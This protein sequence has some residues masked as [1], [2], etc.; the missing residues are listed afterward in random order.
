MNCPACAH[1]NR[2]GAKFCEECAAALPR[3]CASCGAELRATAKFCDECGAPVAAKPPPASAPLSSTSPQAAAGERSESGSSRKIVT[4]VFADLVGSTALHERLDPESVRRFMESYYGAM[5]GAVEAHGGRVT[6]VMGDGVKAVFGA[7]RVAEDDALRAVRAG[8]EMQRAFREL[9]ERE[10]RLVGQTG[11]RVAVNTGEVVADDTTEIIGDP[12]NVA[13]RLQEKGH[14]GDVVIGGETQRI[15]A[16]QVTLALLGSFAL[17]GRSE[18]VKAYR[19]ESLEPP[20]RESAA[21]FVGRDD[22]LARLTSVY[23]AACAKPATQLAVLLGSPGLGKS[24]LIEEFARRLGDAA[25]VMSAHCDAAGGA[26]FAPL[27][28]ALREG[29]GIAESASAEALRNALAALLTAGDAESARVTRGIAALLSGSPAPPEET[30]FVVR[31]LLAALAAAKPVLLVVDDL[32]WAEPLLL[33]LV[34]HLVQWGSGTKLLVLVGARPELRDARSSLATPGGLVADVITL[35]GL[36]AFAATRLAANVIGASDL[37]TAIA[38]KLLTT[39]EGNPLFVGALVRMLVDEGALRREGE[40]WVAGADLAALEMPPTIHAL[41]AAR[42]E[43][44]RPEERGVLERA[45]VVGRHFSRSAVAELLGPRDAA[46]LDARLEALRR[47]ELIERDPGWWLGEPALR[48]HHALIR[49]AAYRRVLKGTRAA[50]HAHL[51]D[52]I[53]ARAGESTEHDE[54]IGWHLEQAHENLRELGPLDAR[55]TALGTRAAQRLAAAGRR[56]LARDDVALAGSLLRRALERLDEADDSRADLALDC[57][58]ALLASGEV[59]PAAVV[60]EELGR[61]AQSERLRAWHTC[62]AA[63]L[64]ALTEP[65]A[66]NAAASS[67]AAAADALARLG[68]AAGE[69]KAHHVH[70]QALARLGRV[71]AAEA[72][73]DRALAAA[74]RAG[75]RRRA[76]A[77]LAGAP[78]AALWGPSPVTRASG[79][80]LDV[81]RVL[82][83]TQDAPAVEAV[84]LSCQG[85]LEALRGRTEAARRM[86]AS[87]RKMVEE[88]GVTQRVLEVDVIAARIDALE[89]DATSAERLLRS[90]ADGLRALG[91]GN[92]AASA[93]AQLGRALLAQGRAAEAEALSH[94]SEALAGDGLQAAIAWRGVRAEALAQRGEHAAAIALAQAAV[95]IASA[96]DALLDHADARLAL[97]SALRAAGRNHEASA[98]E[99]RA[100]SLWEAK[101]ATLLGERTRSEAKPAPIDAGRVAAPSATG[102]VSASARR[103]VHENAAVAAMLALVRAFDARDFS[104]LPALYRDDYRE[105]DHPTGTQFGWGAALA[106]IQL[107]SRS[108]SAYLRVEPLA[109]LGERLALARRTVGARETGGE[110]FD[111]GEYETRRWQLGEIDSSGRVSS[112][113][114]FAENRL[115]D[116]IARLY[117]RFAELLPEGAERTRAEATARS[118]AAVVLSTD[119]DR[120]AL[121][122]DASV[123]IADNRVLHTWSSRGAEEYQHQFRLQRELAPDFAVRDDDV[124]ALDPRALLVCQMYGGSNSAGGA[125][126]NYIVALYSFG[127]D[128]R[129]TSAQ[130]WEPGHEAEALAR[131][132]A[133]TGATEPAPTRRV[134]ENAATPVAA[135]LAAAANAHDE[136]ALLAE[137]TGAISAVDH[138]AGKIFDGSALIA[139]WRRFIR[140]NDSHARADVVASLGESLALQRLQ[141]TAAGVSGGRFDVASYEIEQIV[142]AEV[143]AAAGVRAY[144]IFAPQQLGDAIVR[145]Y[146][147]YAELLPEGAERTRAEVIARSVAASL[148]HSNEP[149]ELARYRPVLAANFELADHRLL[150][151]WSARTPNE[152]VRNLASWQGVTTGAVFHTGDVLALEPSALLLSRTLSGAAS[153]SGGAF[154]RPFLV[155]FAFDEAG[156]VA[157]EEYF[158]VGGESAALARFDE[159]TARVAPRQLKHPF[160]NAASRSVQR[161]VAA[162]EAHDWAG[163]AA[164]ISPQFRIFDRTAFAKLDA[165]R[166]EWLAGFRQ[167]VEMTSGPLEPRVLATRG[168]RLVLVQM[169]WQGAAGDVGPSEIEWLLIIEVDARGDQLAIV[170]FDPHD[171]D[172]AYAEL[173]ARFEAG[174]GRENSRAVGFAAAFQRAFAQRDWAALAAIV[175]PEVVARNHRTVG[176]GTLRGPAEY[177]PA[178]RELVALAP[179]A[180]LRSDHLR[181]AERGLLWEF[182]WRGMREGGAFETPLVTVTELD[183]SARQSRL[184]VWDAGAPEARA[185]FAEIA[186]AVAPAEPFANAASRAFERLTGCFNARDWAGIQTCASPALAYDERRRLLRNT[187]GLREWLA[188]VREFYDVPGSEFRV[189]LLAT[190][191]ERLSL[192]RNSYG[193]GAGSGAP[194]EIEDFVGVYEVDDTGR[195]VGIVLFD[196]DDL[197]AAYAELDARFEAG[198]GAAHPVVVQVGRAF[199]E[200]LARRDWD[201]VLATCAPDLVCHNHRVLGWDTLHGAA[202]WVQL[203]QATAQLSPDYR[204]RVD[205]SRICENGVLMYGQL[206]GTRDGGAFEIPFVRV[207]QIAPGGLVL[208]IDLYDHEKSG[209]AL[210]RFAE[211]AAPAETAPSRFENAASHAWRELMAAWVARDVARWKR[212]QQAV[213]RYRDHRPLMQLDYDRAQLFE[214]ARPLL[215]MRTAGASLQTLATRGERLALERLTI[216]MADDEIGAS[217]IESLMLIETNAAGAITE[218]QRWEVDDLEA[219]YAELDARFEADEGAAH[220]NRAR[221]EFVRAVAARDWSALTAL[222]RAGFV[223]RDHRRLTVL[224]TTNSRDQWLENLRSVVELAPDTQLRFD[225]VRCAQRGF[226]WQVVWTGT[227]DGGRFEIPLVGVFE[228]DDAGKLAGADTWEPEDIA[229]ALARFEDLRASVPRDPLRIPP[230]AA[231]R[232]LDAWFAGT[233]S[234]DVDAVRGLY[235]DSNSLEDRRALL[236]GTFGP[237]SVVPTARFFSEGWHWVRTLLATAGDRLA[238]WR[239]RFTHGEADAASEVEILEVDEVDRGGRIVR[240]VLFDPDARAAASAELFESYVRLGA[241]GM[242]EAQI[243][244]LR[245]MAARDPARIQAALPDAYFVDDHRRL[246]FGRVERDGYVASFTAL[247]EVTREVRIDELYQVAVSASARLAVSRMSG[248]NAE[249]GEFET[250]A[251]WLSRTENG[252]LANSEYFDLEDLDAARVRFEGPAR[253]AV[254]DPLQIPPNAAARAT[255]RQWALWRAGDW[256]ALASLLAGVAY[257]DRRR[258]IRLSGGGELLVAD[259][260]HLAEVGF[261]PRRRLLATTGERVAIEHMLW[262]QRA[263]GEESEIE[264]L[265]VTEVDSAGR[266]VAV[267]ILDADDRAA[268]FDEAR[269]RFIAGEAA[270]V[271]AQNAIAVMNRAIAAADWS[272]FRE[273]LSHDFEMRDLRTLGHGEFA[274]DA[275]VESVRAL[276]GL[277]SGVHVEQLRLLA[278]NRHGSVSVVRTTGVNAAGGEFELLAVGVAIASGDRVALLE[279]YDLTDAERALARFGELCAERERAGV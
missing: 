151:T 132:D 80:C 136:T 113:E 57:S 32:H 7:P 160:A 162:L 277:G 23:E 35:A 148:R 92:D 259:L 164:L 3:A 210:A 131:F 158:D 91:L 154:E 231:T 240:V 266:I 135:R 122:L 175:A 141:L 187:A 237:E 257:E 236:R 171:L 77:V 234:G 221:G 124:L 233:A 276:A 184:D 278:W 116:A 111:V 127:D 265:R 204:P 274:R 157:R 188:G 106:S 69:A 64:T 19:V 264:V 216:E 89:G 71:G 153:A 67:V 102:G 243:E 139:S 68:D 232:A 244:L 93:L 134:R 72:A 165:S 185:R 129:V 166:E 28:R 48:F 203:L 88:L 217:A 97:A 167:Q 17:K 78:L 98:E 27:A 79:R 189:S 229:Q 130:V 125:F 208:R 155:L 63:Q 270:D 12:V 24:R 273:S 206:Y 230:N 194:F 181:C 263:S 245:G 45:A 140:A 271:G 29:L 18:P 99:K 14:D 186:T 254:R 169:V 90:A 96:T 21:A 114:V 227:R 182:A 66:L 109:A 40:R 73:L 62:F 235:A 58:E 251:V 103:R 94:E 8:V 126:E 83:I 198:E 256:D 82:R 205:H 115:G 212:I 207:N 9:A 87:A 42:I 112:V 1:A 228:I 56:A 105:I 65:S 145:L 107:F 223:E 31:R 250:F 202:A 279:R 269:A 119:P 219:A 86:V 128:G 70:A 161:G 262:T 36:D 142:V 150:G 214:F 252:Q 117:A 6:Q 47:A 159:L 54:T 149:A 193:G 52:W 209:A 123:W 211:L 11:L 201:A 242:P 224:R 253:S 22:E 4:I 191:G 44:L 101:G 183:E 121:A 213:V 267:V 239:I 46:E 178:L 255:D 55:G 15:V 246:G 176:W 81:V 147:R 53:E 247:N 170:S 248:V 118:V 60:I 179:D 75:D 59:A 25:T 104:G 13:A 50:L 61:L 133:L 156:L 152:H 168:E 249:G 177:V 195:I 218:Y 26:T 226:F 192:H 200:A 238:L 163:F 100:T 241:D 272:A 110:R 20:A 172:A 2:P 43:R 220:A 268:A 174:E 197:D 143:N 108:E 225:H 275:H 37:P 144:E 95:E 196:V 261:P 76:N 39:S 84:A 137:F 199:R 41:L 51:A 10:A 30:F 49:D 222:C 146:S 34:E 173:D 180:T 38:A 260:R 138:T 16:A 190:R 85:V 215:E 33:D 120:L 258:V 74:R 5:R